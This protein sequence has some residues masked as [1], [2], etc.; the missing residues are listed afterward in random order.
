ML[1][2]ELDF[3]MLA[4]D[5]WRFLEIMSLVVTTCLSGAY[6]YV[7]ELL[8]DDLSPKRALLFE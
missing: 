5:Y 1:A 3:G 2:H 7:S 8:Q 4:V 6:G